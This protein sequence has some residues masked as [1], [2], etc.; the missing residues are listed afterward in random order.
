VLGLIGSVALAP[1]LVACDAQVIGRLPIEPE[2]AGWS[3]TLPEPGV[4]RLKH[5]QALRMKA[6][7]PSLGF[8]L[9]LQPQNMG[10]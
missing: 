5:N 4:A 1:D 8:S 9:L 6:R 7:L 3:G 10:A 2:L